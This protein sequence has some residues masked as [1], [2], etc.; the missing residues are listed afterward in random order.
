MMVQVQTKSEP[1]HV[2][3]MWLQG[4]LK[5]VSSFVDRRGRQSMFFAAEFLP[6]LGQLRS[7]LHG[8][9]PLTKAPATLAQLLT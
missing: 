7:M 4:R 1:P 5:F 6:V 2:F 9:V 3:N 8:E